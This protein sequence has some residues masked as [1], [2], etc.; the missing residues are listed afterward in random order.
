[1][2]IILDLIVVGILVA[3]VIIGFKRGFIKSLMGLVSGILALVIAFLFSPALARVVDD[4]LIR[5][6]MVSAVEEK[7]VSSDPTDGDLLDFLKNAPEDLN[8]FFSSIGVDLSRLDSY[9][10]EGEEQEG[11][12]EGVLTTVSE[13]LAAPLSNMISTVIAFVVVY[14]TALILLKIVTALLDGLFKLPILRIPN[15]LLGAA[16][17][18]LTGVITCFVICSVVGLVLPYLAEGE[19][20]L[21]SN[22]TADKTLL[23]RYF[24]GFDGVSE[25]LGTILK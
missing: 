10:P 18:A 15:K 7:I 9:L 13:S 21:F 16:I 3:T 14:L 8:Q 25:L 17:G 1:M 11:E 6:V 19:N 24:C 4:H 2:N 23:F 22:V 12:G 5:P 20:T